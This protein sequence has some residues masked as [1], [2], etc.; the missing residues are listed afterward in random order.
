MSSPALPDDELAA[1]LRLVGTPG[2]GRDSVRRL[3]AAFG[4]AEAVFAADERAW[5]TVVVPAVAAALREPIAGHDRLVAGVLAWRAAQPARRVMVLGEPD[6]PEQLLNTA[7]PPLLLYL[8]GDTS[9]LAARSVAVVGSRRPTPQ[10]RENARRF[11]VALAREGWTVVSGLAAG[12]DAAAHEGALQAGERGGRTIAVIGTGIDK[13][14]PAHHATLQRHL[15]GQGGL[16][17]S[18]LPLGAPPL[19]RHF[20]QRNRIIAGLARGTL[21]VEA[22]LR[23]GSL[24]TARLAVEAGREVMVVPGSILAEQSAGGHEL[25][26]QGATLVV[27]VEQVLEAL[28]MPAAAPG[29][30][31]GP[32]AGV[33]ARAAAGGATAAGHRVTSGDVD[34][35]PEGGQDG[36]DDG[37]D[38]PEADDEVLRALG[39]DPTSLDALI[40][41]CGWPA[42]ALNAHL[43]TL[44]LAG[45]VARLPGGL[46]QRIATG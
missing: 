13:V 24:I 17:V 21:V 6:Y 11:A 8:E 44:E 41:R 46:Y 37:D 15:L 10:G 18:E 38:R 23:S 1:W 36:G 12:I 5:R 27:S 14:Y 26:R 34:D 25:I 3:L 28:G 42:P 29:S 9:L 39:H 22:A 40:A 32:A 4:S 35:D 7:D 33:A 30:A 19:A 2:V 31:A 20:P 43:L 45:L 16:V